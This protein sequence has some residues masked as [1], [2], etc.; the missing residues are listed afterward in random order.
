MNSSHGDEKLASAASSA[1]FYYQIIIFVNT[2][3]L[4]PQILFGCGGNILNLIVLLSRAMRSRTNL[5]FS[6]MAFADL[7]FLILH[8]PTV[9]FYT[10]VFMHSQ[11]YR[12]LAQYVSGM[13]NWFSAI[14]I[15]CMMYATIERVQVFRSPF[16]TSKRSTSPRFIAIMFLIVVGSLFLTLIHFVSPKTRAV[17]KI[18]RYLVLLHMLL[19]VLV[20]LIVSAALNILLILALKQNSMPLR[21]LND[22]HVHQSLIIARSK[23]ERKVTIMVSV[24][25]TSFIICNAPGAIFFLFKEHDHKNFDKEPRN[26]MIQAVCNSLTVT[27]KVLNFLLFC[28]SSEHFRALLKKRLCYL[29]HWNMNRRNTYSTTATKTFSVP[30]SDI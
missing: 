12:G 17:H 20:P 10:R 3:I 27:G 2:K 25:L 5:I 13:T 26:V 8:I 24:I 29:L 6:A 16:R 19:V 21:M 22:S 23:T 15:W 9:L 18:S 30:L 7:F 1:H 4:I 28:L 14:S 11:W